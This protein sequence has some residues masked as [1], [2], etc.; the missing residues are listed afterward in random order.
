[1]LAIF[2]RSRTEYES[3]CWTKQEEHDVQDDVVECRTE[4]ERN[5]FCTSD[6]LSSQTQLLSPQMRC[7]PRWRRSAF[8][9]LNSVFLFDMYSKVEEKCE[10]NTSGYTTTTEC[11]KWPRE[12]CRLVVHFKDR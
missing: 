9:F 3:E 12:V 2:F 1:M 7:C 6:K 4:V 10:P 5:I 11:K 8:K